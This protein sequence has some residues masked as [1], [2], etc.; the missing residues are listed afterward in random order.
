MLVSAAMTALIESS[1]PA[2]HEDPRE[3]AR[4]AGLRYVSDLSPGIRRLKSGRGFRY[5]LEEGETVKDPETLTRIR[6][7]VIPPAW[8]SVWISPAPRGH[9]QATGRDQRGRKQ[10]RY[11]V[12]WREVRDSTKYGR[13]AELG[14]T[15]PL[16]RDRVQTDLAMRGLPREKVL[17]LL[18]ELLDRTRIRIGNEMYA[19]DNKSYDLT[20]FRNRHAQVNSTSVVFQFR[21]KSG[22]DHNVSLHDR[23]VAAV[24]KRCQELPGQHLFQYLD[25]DGVHQ[26]IRSEDVNEY[27]RSISGADFTAKDFRT[28]WGT[29]IV[30]TALSDITPA[31]TETARKHAV[32]EAIKLAAEEL[33][34]TTAVCRKCY[35]HPLVIDSYMDGEVISLDSAL[36]GLSAEETGVLEMLER[37]SKE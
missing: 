6:S 34:N 8:I 31:E 33:G 29:V 36:D 17:A 10:Y 28:W 20:S 18:I 12:K 23:R 5:V 16:I 3:V 24:I 15:L 32:V 9:I 14:R 1:P 35:V 21:G 25:D 27:I 11:H 4:H 2:E 22:K 13:L 26:S 19:R 7:L 37:A 30:A